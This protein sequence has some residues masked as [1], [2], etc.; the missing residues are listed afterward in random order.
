MNGCVVQVIRPQM[1]FKNKTYYEVLLAV[2]VWC[3]WPVLQEETFIGLYTS[4]S[5][6]SWLY[7]QIYLCWSFMIG[8]LLLIPLGKEASRNKLTAEWLVP[9]CAHFQSNLGEE[10]IIMNLDCSIKVVSLFIGRMCRLEKYGWLSMRLCH[11]HCHCY[12]WCVDGN[13]DIVC[14]Q[15]CIHLISTKPCYIDTS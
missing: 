1:N 2:P 14:L 10:H 13:V 8:I 7:S 5:C 11:C 3:L 9:L 12:W 4:R 6:W 15:A